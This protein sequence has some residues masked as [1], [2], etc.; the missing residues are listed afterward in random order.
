M[1]S[2]GGNWKSDSWNT[3]KDIFW[4]LLF[5]SLSYKIDSFSSIKLN[6]DNDL[7]K[8]NLNKVV[9]VFEEH[10]I[11]SFKFIL[12]KLNKRQLMIKFG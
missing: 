11:H 1:S 3:F 9:E 7:S 8:S 6:Y 10:I 12:C 4:L 5:F 2:N